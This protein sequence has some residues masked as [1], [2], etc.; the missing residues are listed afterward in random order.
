MVAVYGD[1]RRTEITQI[2]D[3][4]KEEKEIEFVE[5]EKCVV[6]MTESGLIKRIPTAAFRTQKRNGKGV[7]TTDDII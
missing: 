6:V 2:A 3:A 5:P 4:T 1:E 7:K